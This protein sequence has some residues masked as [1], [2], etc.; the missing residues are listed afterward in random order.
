[1][2]TTWCVFCWNEKTRKRKLGIKINKKSVS[3]E[4]KKGSLD[5]V[6]QL[7]NREEINLTIKNKHGETA[8]EV[9]KRVGLEGLTEYID[10]CEEI[11]QN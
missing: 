10:V 5:I 11:A 6:Y 8:S 3:Q 2:E 7:L 9:A 4:A 1:M